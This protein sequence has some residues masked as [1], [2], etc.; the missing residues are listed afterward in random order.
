MTL[1]V[2][3]TVDLTGLSRYLLIVLRKEKSIFIEEEGALSECFLSRIVQ[4]LK[5]ESGKIIQSI[6][7][8][9]DFTAQQ[10]KFIG[11]G[12]CLKRLIAEGTGLR[13]CIKSEGRRYLPEA[14]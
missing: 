7:V 4:L 13:N 11:R 1:A 3:T 8:L 12:R 5:T 14:S 9:F 10:G 6:G 2:P